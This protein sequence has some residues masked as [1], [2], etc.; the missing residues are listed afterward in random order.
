MKISTRTRY[1]LRFLV[2]LA[3]ARPGT[4]LSLGLAAGKERIS[5]KYLSRL[6]I[7]LRRAGLVVS[8]A[9]PL[10]GYRLAVP[11]DR[12]PVSAVM[13]LFE[14]DAGLAPCL[15][16]GEKCRLAPR[17]RTRRFWRSLDRD[18]ARR[19]DRTTIGDIARGSPL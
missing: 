13:N 9:G 19:L 5:P 4:P 3:L 17:C 2:R 1:A 8:S 16:A 14:R 15:G 18:I 12:I 7:P 11:P 10:G 6:V